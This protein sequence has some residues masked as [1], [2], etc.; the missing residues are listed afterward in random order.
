M[1]KKQDAKLLLHRAF[2]KAR[3]EVCLDG[4]G[5]TATVE[6]NLID[7]VRLTDFEDDLRQGNGNELCEDAQGRIKFCAAHSS[8]A[9]AVNCFAPFKRHLA[10]LSLL[11]ENG[12]HAMQFETRCPSGLRGTPPNLDLVIE[13]KNIVIGIESKFTEHLDARSQN[14][15][16]QEFADSY[17][18]NQQASWDAKWVAEMRRIKN[19]RPYKYLDAAQLVKHAFGLKNTFGDDCVLL[20][21]FW[22]PADA[23]HQNFI[24]HREE[25][26][27]LSRRVD[28]ATPSFTA[29]SY[30]ELW[31]AWQDNAA[32]WLSE[33]LAHLRARYEVSA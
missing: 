5:Y 3:P 19:D 26:A 31:R 10:D 15:H 8:S 23:A 27:C 32:P 18:T 12:F 11:G 13:N 16:G 22:Q 20:Y 6:E 21:V 24:N 9:L 14:K 28:G 4:K 7:G 1:M 2:G 29:M 30:S 17:M 25:I 33:H